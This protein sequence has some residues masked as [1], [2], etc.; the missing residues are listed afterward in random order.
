VDRVLHCIW[1]HQSHREAAANLQ[2]LTRGK[3]LDTWRTT[4]EELGRLHMPNQHSFSIES[5]FRTAKLTMNVKIRKK[6]VKMHT[7]GK[8]TILGESRYRCSLP[9]SHPHNSPPLLGQFYK[10]DMQEGYSHDCLLSSL[11]GSTDIH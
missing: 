9:S 2:D 6:N 7:M 8:D 4:N 10:V 3:V 5:L 11:N 1:Q